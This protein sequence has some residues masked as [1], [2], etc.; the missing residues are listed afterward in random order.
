ML[1]PIEVGDEITYIHHYYGSRLTGVVVA[2]RESDILVERRNCFGEVN[3][4]SWEHVV[5]I[6]KKPCDLEVRYD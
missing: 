4:T 1:T 5:R 3:N 6:D 2:V